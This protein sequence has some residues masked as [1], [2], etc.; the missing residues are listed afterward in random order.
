MT[1]RSLNA[2]WHLFLLPLALVIS[3]VS[4]ASAHTSGEAVL[5]EAAKN[6]NREVVRALVRQ[7]ADV[8]ARQPDGATALHWAARW[9]D[10]ETA[11]LLVDAAAS[12]NAHT[13]LGVTPLY[14]ACLNGSPRMVEALLTAGADVTSTRPTGETVL[15]TCSRSGS[16]DGVRQLLA[17]GADVGAREHRQGQ[18]ALMW[19]AAQ[20]HA[21]VA[22]VLI[23]RGADVHAKTGEAGF[24]PL[25]FA[26]RNGARDVARILLAEGA[27][28]DQAASD[29][30]NA[31]VAATIMGHWEL[32]QY[33]LEHGADPNADGAGYTPLHW[34]AGS[35]ET[36]IS[37]KYGP[38]E[39]RWIAGLLPGKLELVKALL[40]H[41]ANPN[42]RIKIP[43]PR[44]GYVGVIRKFDLRGATPLLLALTGGHLDIAHVLLAGG[45]DPKPTTDDGT[46]PLM[47]AA[48]LGHTVGQ[49][50][51]SH[52]DAFNAV[53]LAVELGSD[54][55]AANRNGDTGLHAAADFGADGIVQFLV[56]SGGDVN[57]VN[58]IGS[59][60]LTVA[61]ASVGA[62]RGPHE[63]AAALLRQLGGIGDVEIEGAIVS[64]GAPC[65]GTRFDV[66]PGRPQSLPGSEPQR[67]AT[68]PLRVGV[69][70]MTTF[71]GGACADLAVGTVLKITGTRALVRG[72]VQAS[73]V[74]VQH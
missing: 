63:S 62:L 58:A 27:D 34:V 4:F 41:G 73:A 14:L 36:D 20:G 56:D 61:Q 45:A 13:D 35:W 72:A 29:G 10:V 15:M 1:N 64:F 65:P 26:A 53:K 31:L 18:T 16:V 44:F 9:D 21:D 22:H 30:T 6:R 54:V 43:P 23:E 67:R 46:T 12:V 49:S 52:E 66:V 50:L 28:I 42:A 48:G 17:H 24:A 68:R 7:G 32:A 40:A 11:T 70:T 19:A 39:Y 59:R 55:N 57:A 74:A 51:I 37:G 3:G 38:D 8:N 69:T 2:G 5:A 60:P 25:L 71:T 33:L 47:A